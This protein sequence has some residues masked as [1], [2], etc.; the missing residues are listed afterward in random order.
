VAFPAA[1]FIG[2]YNWRGT[3]SA[4]LPPEVLNQ[5]TYWSSPTFLW[6]KERPKIH[7]PQPEFNEFYN[8]MAHEMWLQNRPDTFAKFWSR[9]SSLVREVVKF[10]IWPELCLPLLAFPWILR[11]RRARFLFAEFA[12]CFFGL[13]LVP[14]FLP[15]YLAPLTGCIF[16]LLVQGTRHLRI[17]KFGGRLVG[18]GL[19]RVMVLF[20]IIPILIRPQGYLIP[21]PP[22]GIEYRAKLKAQLND[23]P[24]K[25][26]VIV[27]YS[28]NHNVYAE[29]VHNDADIDSAK[30]V[31]ARDIPGIAL[32]PLLDYFRGRHIW[33]V[34]PDD[35][36]PR[37]VPFSGTQDQR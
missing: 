9:F 28:Q 7:F 24:G 23:A 33:T 29:W 4:L 37:L 34:E 3:G 32:N 8:V 17:W 27:R 26:L 20:A 18:M 30:V 1:A 11:S 21:E 10:F 19:P 13:F 15:H 2:Y 6:Q 5:R 22:R 12:F 25:H 36:S 31:W 35:A 16:A 14:W